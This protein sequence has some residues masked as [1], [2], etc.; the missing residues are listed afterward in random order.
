MRIKR[1]KSIRIKLKRNLKLPKCHYLD[2]TTTILMMIHLNSMHTLT[3]T[4]TLHKSNIK[5]F[6][7]NN[8]LK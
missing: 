6:D 4:H 1:D 7:G 2:T 5:Y 3:Q 8:F